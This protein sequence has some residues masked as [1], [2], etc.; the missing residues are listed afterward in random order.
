MKWARVQF[1]LLVIALEASSATSSSSTTILSRS[2]QKVN[3]VTGN[4]IPGTCE[5]ITI[6]VNCN[7]SGPNYCD[8]HEGHQSNIIY[9]R[10]YVDDFCTAPLRMQ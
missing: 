6:E 3:I 9:W 5:A 2:R 10:Y 4:V 8:I 7:L 1:I